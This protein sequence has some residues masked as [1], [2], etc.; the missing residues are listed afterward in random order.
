M[1]CENFWI[2]VCPFPNLSHSPSIKLFPDL[3]D[4]TQAGENIFS[5]L[6]AMV[7]WFVDMPCFLNTTKDM[8]LMPKLNKSRVVMLEQNKSLIVDAGT[9]QKTFCRRSKTK[10]MLL[11]P[12][13]K[14][15][16]HVVDAGTNKKPYCWSKNKTKAMSQCWN[17][18]KHAMLLMPKPNKSHVVVGAKQNQCCWCRNKKNPSRWCRNK[19][20]AMSLCWTNLSIGY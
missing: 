19:T 8:L 20:K 11:M 15:K 2:F 10:S 14:T 12:E 9:K 1:N 18:T 5:Y 6:P 4:A 7:Y 17:K 13:K 16:I 3:I